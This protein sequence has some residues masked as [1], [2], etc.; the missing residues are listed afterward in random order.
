MYH[1]NGM[2]FGRNGLAPQRNVFEMGGL[3]FGQ[4]TAKTFW[5]TH[6]PWFEVDP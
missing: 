5:M 4:K 1:S 6:Y 2:L 3:W